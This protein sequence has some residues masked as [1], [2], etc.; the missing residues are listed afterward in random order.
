MEL[1]E[2]C[3]SKCGGKCCYLHL[4]GEGEPIPCPR[5]KS[6]NTCSVY[7]ERY[8]DGQ[9]DLVVVG[10]WTSKR[11]RELDGRPAQRPFVCGRVEQVHQR[12]G[13][14]REIADRCAALHPELLEE[15]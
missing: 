4:N 14:P 11:L 3:R 7:K 8:A 5:L 13:L 15:A 9:P 1:V 2:Y 10:Y 6:D 12:G